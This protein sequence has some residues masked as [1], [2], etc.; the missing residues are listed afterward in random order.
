MKLVSTQQQSSPVLF[1]EAMFAG[2]AADGGLFVPGQLP[3][4]PD[5]QA[6]SLQQLGMKIMSALLDD[7]APAV[8]QQI[9]QQALDFPIPLIKLQKNI[10]LLEVFHGPTLAFKDVGARFMANMM[11]FY[12][13][14]ENKHVTIMVATSGDTGSA[15][16]NAFHGMPHIDVVILYPSQKITL[17]QEKQMT[18]LDGNVHALEIQ[19]TFDDCQRLVKTALQ[20]VSLR[21]QK[22]VTTANSI[23]IARLLPQIIYH[24][25]GVMQLRQ[26]GINEMPVMSVPSGNLGNLTAAVYAQAMGLPVKH[27]IAATN[28]NAILPD[29]LGSGVFSPKPSRQTCSNAMDVGNPS[30]FERLQTYYQHSCAAM[31]NAITGVSI[32]DEETLREIRHTYE[33]TK[34]IVDPHTAV[35][36]SAVKRVGVTSP[37]IVTATAHPA[38]FPEVIK[39]AINIDVEMPASLRILMS[40][41][42]QSVLMQADYNDLQRYLLEI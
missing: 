24:A 25:W 40:K 12:L 33:T 32:S 38:K 4:L 2:M 36:L 19:G 41:P 35:G 20:D 29:Y 42:K 5:I 21:K 17:L 7:I 22:W 30:N 16:A 8:L 26:S 3:V 6:A 31:R 28:A 23:N 39:Q 9:L 13:A 14:N 15:I 27:F 10:Y 18:T 34:Y 1:R 37:V 11:A